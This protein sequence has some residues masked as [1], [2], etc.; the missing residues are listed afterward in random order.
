M[1]AQALDE[2]I[3]SL[4]ALGDAEEIAAGVARRAAPLLDAAVKATASAGQ[5]PDGKAWQKREDGGAPLKNAAAHIT[6][7]AHGPLVRMT[8]TGAD[9]FHHYGATRGSIRRQVIPDAGAAVP[10]MVTELLLQAAGAE[11]EARTR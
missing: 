8:L 3:A 9:V 2:M 11:F 7:K 1:S 5:S 10:E 6:T 4:R